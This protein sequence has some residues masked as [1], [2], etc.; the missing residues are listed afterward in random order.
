MIAWLPRSIQIIHL[1]LIFDRIIVLLGQCDSQLER[2]QQSVHFNQ[3]WGNLISIVQTSFDNYQKQLLDIRQ[4]QT[5]LIHLD[6]IQ[7]N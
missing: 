6:A 3:Q 4:E 5:L 7:V 2:V 1:F